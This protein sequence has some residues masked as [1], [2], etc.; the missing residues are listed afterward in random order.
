MYWFKATRIQLYAVINGRA[1]RKLCA[2]TS[3][4]HAKLPAA[5]SVVLG[6]DG[7]LGEDHWVAGETSGKLRMQVA[8]EVNAFNASSALGEALISSGSRQKMQ[9]AGVPKESVAVPVL[10]RFPQNFLIWEGFWLQPGFLHNECD[11]QKILAPLPTGGTNSR[12]NDAGFGGMLRTSQSLSL[13]RVGGVHSKFLRPWFFISFLASFWFLSGASY[14][15]VEEKERGAFPLR[16][17]SVFASSA[18]SIPLYFAKCLV[19]DYRGEEQVLGVSGGRRWFFRARWTLVGMMEKNEKWGVILSRGRWTWKGG[20]GED[21]RG[22]GGLR[23]C[24]PAVSGVVWG[25]CLAQIFAILRLVE[26]SAEVARCRIRVPE[27]RV[28]WPRAS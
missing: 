2:R 7:R 19:L 1:A 26:C 9:S 23:A 8:R 5:L 14:H 12:T 6:C 27:R 16:S 28:I 21:A 3:G 22:R 11:G 10:K 13:W 17:L 24:A 18:F 25:F 20:A 4:D 15:R